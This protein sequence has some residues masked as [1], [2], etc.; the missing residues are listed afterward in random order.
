MNLDLSSKRIGY[1]LITSNAM[2][3]RIEQ[4]EEEAGPK[5][6]IYEHLHDGMVEVYDEVNKQSKKLIGFET[7]E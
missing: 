4:K 1:I 3:Q 6:K 7:N 5:S 2:I